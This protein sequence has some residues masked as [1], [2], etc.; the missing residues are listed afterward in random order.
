MDEFIPLLLDSLGNNLLI[1]DHTAGIVKRY[2]VT[3]G[4]SPRVMPSCLNELGWSAAAIFDLGVVTYLD[5]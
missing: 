4:L 1:A 2:A 3:Q 5:T